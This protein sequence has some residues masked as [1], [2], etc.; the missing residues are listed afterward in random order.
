MLTDG[1]RTVVLAGGALTILFAWQAFR[2]MTIGA[3]APERLIGELRLAQLGALV[4]TFSAGTYVGIAATHEAVLGVGLDVAL[5]FGFFLVAAW[6]VL[7]DPRVAL[8]ALA[9]AFAAHAVFTVAHRPGLLPADVAPR[10]FTIGS[11]VYDVV[12]GALCYLPILRRP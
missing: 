3:A 8:T 11:A 7:Q 6:V 10:W 12:I 4:L 2:V 1:L 5:A 9:F